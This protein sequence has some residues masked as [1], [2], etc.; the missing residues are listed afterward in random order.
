MHPS[1]MENGKL[2]FDTYVSRL[3]SVKLVEIGSQDVNGSLRTVAPS[4]VDYIGVDFVEGRGVDVLLEDPYVLPFDTSSVDLVVSSSCFEHSEMFWLVFGEVMRVLR[5]SG[6]FFLNVPSNG[7]FHRYPVDCWRFYPDAANALVAWAKRTGTNAGVLESFV[8][9]QKDDY[10]NDYLAVF[11]KNIEY[12]A[13]H[14]NRILSS[15]REFYNG[16][17]F[18]MDDVINPENM[19]Q[20]IREREYFRKEIERLKKKLEDIERR[21]SSNAGQ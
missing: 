12:A 3:G 10:W 8:T 4:N 2:F 16:M 15:R 6:L 13:E 1:A 17:I 9:P 14:P 7:P 5:P 11:I 20:D 19:P 18:G 21:D